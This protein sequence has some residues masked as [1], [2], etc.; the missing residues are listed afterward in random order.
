MGA[1]SHKRI[2]SVTTDTVKAR[3]CAETPWSNGIRRVVISKTHIFALSFSNVFATVLNRF[4]MSATGGF[5]KVTRRSACVVQWKPRLPL[6]RT[7]HKVFLQV[8]YNLVVVADDGVAVEEDGHLLAQVE[9]HEPRLL[10]LLQRQ[11]HVPLLTD[12]TLLIND[13]TYLQLQ[14]HTTTSSG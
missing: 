9:P 14:T 6:R 7:S 11:A 8:I 13:E 5:A 10:V 3:T 2:D 4:W 1:G 12:Q